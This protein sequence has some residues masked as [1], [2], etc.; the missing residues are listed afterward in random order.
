MK[1]LR[2]LVAI[3]SVFAAAPS[4]AEDKPK[5]SAKKPANQ[6]A[7]SYRTA[8]QIRA[9]KEIGVTLESKHSCFV[10]FED[11]YGKELSLGSPSNTEE[12]RGFIR[13]L[14]VGQSYWLPDA[15]FA[16]QKRNEKKK[17]TKSEPVYATVA[18]FMA[19]PACKAKTDVEAASEA[20]FTTVDG[21]GFWIGGP[22]GAKE[23]DGFLDSL[24]HGRAYELPGAFLEYEKHPDYISVARITSMAPRTGK[25]TGIGPCYAVF[26][27]AEGKAFS[28]GDPSSG[29]EVTHFLLTLKEGASYKLP[30][31]FLA[32]H[33]APRYVTAKEVTAMP[34]CTA[35]LLTGA[36]NSEFCYF[37][38]AEGK[39]IILGAPGAGKRG[40]DV[41]NFLET[42]EEGKSYE[43]PEA[44]LEYQKQSHAQKQ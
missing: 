3:I 41:L 23:F 7:S 18:Q 24:W 22:G 6:E 8:D 20:H 1:I 12:V 34:H 42:L 40:E 17:Q 9:M 25:V 43:L 37:T 15:F 35:K 10:I 2:H 16:Y 14:E 13:E 31:A 27:M 26:E 28:I 29:A 39:A 30:D 11:E 38:T 5:G 19:M 4:I 44:F 33:A 36:I 32:Y 21:K